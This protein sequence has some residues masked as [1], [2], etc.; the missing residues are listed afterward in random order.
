M[1]LGSY[2]SSHICYFAY[3]NLGFNRFNEFLNYNLI[4]INYL[5][6]LFIILFIINFNRIL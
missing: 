6:Y 3:A 4:L 2:I 5:F 1:A